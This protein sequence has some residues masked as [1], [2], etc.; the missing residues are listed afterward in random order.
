MDIVYTGEQRR[1]KE[2]KREERGGEM[3][4]ERPK[5]THS[6]ENTVYREHIL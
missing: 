6:V 1:A 5:R 3:S 4:K 2:S